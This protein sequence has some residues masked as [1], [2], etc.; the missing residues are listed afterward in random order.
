MLFL[1]VLIFH[2]FNCCY[3]TYYVVLR[4]IFDHFETLLK[5]GSILWTVWRVHMANR[6]SSVFNW[7]TDNA[8]MIDRKWT[9]T[10][11]SSKHY[12]DNLKLSNTHPTKI[13]EWPHVLRIGIVSSSCYTSCTHRSCY[14]GYKPVIGHGWEKGGIMIS[15]SVTYSRSF[16]SQMPRNCFSSHGDDRK[17]FQV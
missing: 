9:K 1:L 2:I 3:C 15:I 11:R 8:K 7:T 12:T 4:L 17:T 5:N 6:R 13:R 14:S 10:P 16:V